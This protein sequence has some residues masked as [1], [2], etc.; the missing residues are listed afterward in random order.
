M[1]N[2]R[3][4]DLSHNPLGLTPDLRNFNACRSLRL[5]N[6]GLTDVPVGLFAMPQL[7]YADLS[8]NAIIELPDPLPSPADGRG[9]TYDFSN[10]PLSLESQQR[11]TIYNATNETRLQEEREW[12][13]SAYQALDNFRDMS[14]SD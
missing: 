12:L 6:T 8:A 5:S 13:A 4:L 11:L 10:N 2:L 1:E 14:F 3:I 9:A 7:T